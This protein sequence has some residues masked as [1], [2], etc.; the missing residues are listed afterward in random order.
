MLATAIGFESFAF[1]QGEWCA[2]ALGGEVIERWEAPF[3]DAMTGTMTVV[4]DGKIAFH[5]FF[6]LTDSGTGWEIRLKHFNPDMASWEEKDEAVVFPL[7]RATTRALEFEGLTMEQRVPGVA[8]D[9]TVDTPDGK[10]IVF[11]YRRC[12]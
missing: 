6:V 11:N 12:D 9:V 1:L 8:L 5:E 4:R 3:G 7:V 10:Q 2:S